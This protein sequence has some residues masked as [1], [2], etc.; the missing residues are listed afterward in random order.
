MLHYMLPQPSDSGKEDPK[1]AMF[2][3]T[4]IPTLFKEAYELG[5]QKDNLVVCVA[6]GSTLLKDGAGFQIGRR[7]HTMLRKLF[8]KNNVVVAAEDVGGS[9]ARTMS[10]DLENG[11]T[12]IRSGGKENVLWQHSK[13][14]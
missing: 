13:S 6:G 12:K 10:L 11:V 2:A 14:A 1:V 7:N 9:E 3:T 5:A 4:G 8:F